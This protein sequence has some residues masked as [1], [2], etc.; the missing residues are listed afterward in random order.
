MIRIALLFGLAAFVLQPTASFS[1][2]RLGN[3][4]RVGGHDFSNRTYNKDKK[5]R[6]Y[7]HEGKPKKE[8]CRWVHEK[9]K[10]GKLTGRKTQVCHLKRK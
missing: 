5:A 6:I 10:H 8:G 3:N 9:D 7:L 1:E 2:V 4:V